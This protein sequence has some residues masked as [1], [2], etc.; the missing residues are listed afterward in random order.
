MDSVI[1]AIATHYLNTESRAK[2]N[3]DANNENQ[4]RSQNMDDNLMT[5]QDVD[6]CMIDSMVARGKRMHARV[7][8]GSKE[9]PA[10]CAKMLIDTGCSGK[11]LISEK[12]AKTLNLQLH[13]CKY[14][15]RTAQGGQ[16]TI[17]G[18]TNPLQ[19]AMQGCSGEFKWPFLVVRNLCCPGVFGMDFL[20]FYSV[21]IQTDKNGTNYMSF[22][23]WPG[24]NVPLV[25]PDSSNLPQ[26]H[27]D[28]R[29]KGASV[30]RQRAGKNPTAA[31]LQEEVGCT[32]KGRASGRPPDLA[33]R[34]SRLIQASQVASNSGC[35]LVPGPFKAQEP[36]GVNTYQDQLTDESGTQQQEFKHM[37]GETQDK[38]TNE[39]GGT[40]QQ[41][42]EAAEDVI[43]HPPTKINDS[44]Q[45]SR[46]GAMQHIQALQPSPNVGGDESCPTSPEASNTETDNAKDEDDDEGRDTA[47]EEELEP[48]G[49]EGGES[50]DPVDMEDIPDL[51]ELRPE[52]VTRLPPHHRVWIPCRAPPGR[53]PNVAILTD[54]DGLQDQVN[55]KRGLVVRPTVNY[56]RKGRVHVLVENMSDISLRL[57]PSYILA[58]GFPMAEP[59]VDWARGK[60]THLQVLSIL[61]QE[62]DSEQG[63]KRDSWPTD[64]ELASKGR[65]SWWDPCRGMSKE[66]REA[67][68]TDTFKLEENQYLKKNPEIMKELKSLLADHTDVYAGKGHTEAIP[69]TTWV[70]LNLDLKPGSQPIHQKPRPL[71]PP[72]QED[73]ERQLSV[74]LRQRVIIPAVP[75]AY[76][77][78]LVPVRKKGVAAS[79]RRW[80][81][82]ARPINQQT[83]PRPEFI[84]TVSANLENL[85]D[86]SLFIAIDLANSFLSIPLKPQDAH[87]LSFVT[88]RHGA[89]TMLRSGYGLTNS[90][91]AL[92]QLS[93]ALM[94][95]IKPDDGSHYVDDYLLHNNDPHKLLNSFRIFL[96]QLRAANVKLQTS[97]TKL[98]QTRVLYLGHMVVGDKDPD[99]EA[100]LYMDPDLVQTIMGT[101]VPQ[102]SAGLKR[103]LGQICFYSSFLPELSR[104]IGC[105]H[106]AKNRVPFKLAKEEVEAF[107]KTKKM[108]LDSPALSFPDFENIEKN[109]L[110]IAGD[111]SGGACSGTLH[112]MQRGKL[113]LLGAVG[114]VNRGSAERWS[115]ARGEASALKLC[116]TKWRHL[117]I[118]YKIY[119]LTD[120]LSLTYIKTA[121]D[122]TGFFARLG[123][124]LTQFDIHFIFRAGK[125]SPVED[126]I[127]RQLHHPPWSLQE[128]MQLADHEDEEE[129]GAPP[130]VP[131]TAPLLAEVMG[132]LSQGLNKPY[133]VQGAGHLDH[134]PEEMK[135][136][137]AFKL[138]A[139][140]EGEEE[141][142]P[143]L[144]TME[145]WTQALEREH[146]LE[147]KRGKPNERAKSP[148]FTVVKVGLDQHWVPVELEAEVVDQ[149]TMGPVADETNGDV[150]KLAAAL[151]DLKMLA[152][153][154]AETLDD[155][156]EGKN[157][158]L[159]Q[160]FP[161]DADE[162]D[163]PDEDGKYW[164]E[165]EE[166][167]KQDFFGP[168][169][170]SETT[171]E[172]EE[173][174]GKNLPVATTTGAN[175]CTL[176]LM[177]VCLLGDTNNSHH[178]KP[179]PLTLSQ[180][181]RRQRAD[182]IV[183]EV[184]GW[185]ERGEKPSREQ[186]RGRPEDL[187]AYRNIFELLKM[188]NGV[189]YRT[190]PVGV[191]EHLDKWRWC[192]PTN[193][194]TDS[195]L[196]AHIEEGAH[197][198]TESTLNRSVQL[199][200]WP[201]QR[202]D[203]ADFCAACPGCKSR[204]GPPKPHR[205]PWHQ[206]MLQSKRGEVLYCDTVGP[207]H[208]A[209]DGGETYIFTTMD[210]FTRYATATA[211]PNK[212][213]ETMAKCLKTYVDVWGPPEKLF[214][215]RGKE[216]DNEVMRKMAED[217]RISRTFSLP[218]LPRQNKVERMHRTIGPLLKAVLAENGDYE[219]WPKYLP[220]IMR[221]YNTSVHAVTGFTP[222][223]L[224]TGYEYPGPLLRWVNPPVISK[225]EDT[226]EQVMRETREST[227][228]NMQAITN[229]RVYQRRQS[230]LYQTSTPTFIPQVGDKV[231]FFCPVAVKLLSKKGYIA[232]KLA[233]QW[234][235][236]WLVTKK[237]SDLVYEIKT[238]G[239]SP[240]KTR[241]TTTDR[242]D[243]YREGIKLNSQETSM[244]L[245]ERH[246][247]TWMAEDDEFA[248]N[249]ETTP[250]YFNEQ[251]AEPHQQA[252][253]V[254]G[255]WGDVFD[256]LEV[257]LQ[258][259]G[260]PDQPFAELEDEM[261]PANMEEQ[262]RPAGMETDE[263]AEH[264]RERNAVVDEAPA[265]AEGRNLL[266][267]REPSLGQ[268]AVPKKQSDTP[269]LETSKGGERWRLRVRMRD[270]SSRS[271]SESPARASASRQL[272]A[273]RRKEREASLASKR[274]A[275]TPLEQK[276]AEERTREIGGEG[277]S[278]RG[279]EEESLEQP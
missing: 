242:L 156:R 13:P 197:M 95:P 89:Y 171:S 214:C 22:L 11:S 52:K 118:R 130:A 7:L 71:S 18:E 200:W 65:D 177:C 182:L 110:I 4:N 231:Y 120:N 111:F 59:D 245:D 135:L 174:S 85:A 207:L 260:A 40:Q 187:H 186:L 88:A 33:T 229:Q 185:V 236:P 128:K 240:E 257:S 86:K 166:H 225:D 184:I 277:E 222:Q 139:I 19:F 29:F 269:L 157:M 49:G 198:A 279:G 249:I 82:D 38:E 98:F 90:P 179:A 191:A 170:D 102:D 278:K 271:A 3:S 104:T 204:S 247:L 109:P 140:E 241:T 193:S 189:L 226:S 208:K 268:G 164:Y 154:V 44:E 125:E 238:I 202:R 261:A 276:T 263:T 9:K 10:I 134:L 1:A 194:V 270:T 75:G 37:G 143:L 246:P 275:G 168:E 54:D 50:V 172:E 99:K 127:S 80:C 151:E 181:H 167:R 178:L 220:E 58:H 147:E 20:T 155:L 24:V 126:S 137:E 36:R 232:K 122:S 210:G 76:A 123:E 93:T 27:E 180:K 67:W 119:Y 227:V 42:S 206:P 92:A 8:T 55:R 12:F 56:I 60:F 192:V 144:E 219:H 113:R 106:Q 256:E 216:L 274:E 234:T 77:L 265:G 34:E 57:N 108:L 47:D 239:N 107:E 212:K 105:L 211:V 273:A 101:E 68:C 114:R 169:E 230:S 43:G 266:T 152:P 262:P 45:T 235:G 209:A 133:E 173:V 159:Q 25:E 64:E 163:W 66:R 253:G 252:V 96:E 190:P 132:E 267:P 218:Y 264:D 97:K 199:T 259:L 138:M 84:G 83:I 48:K 201:S 17:L 131:Q 81:I 6:K 153:D 205:Q 228:R 15:I 244:I 70:S 221:G 176:P 250:T 46:E 217:L 175:L 51:I 203:I 195:L 160:F 23:E 72:D 62:M 117:L 215:D 213:A 146:N 248:E 2:A 162:Y 103:W 223:R 121:K 165:K 150:E 69:M 254:A 272:T 78:N 183:R 79:V 21:G 5:T 158:T 255:G 31:A 196:V 30:F 161:D 14:S 148:D 142:P 112:Q 16:V 41:R 53:K 116:L 61:Q 145:S 224:H 63:V 35:S 87:K 258:P 100:G 237:L 136:E 73:L 233:A 74:W 124:Y 141:E 115:A 91:A 129:E 243:K 149:S 188:E 94:R 28:P 39:G 26:Y 251:S 32:S